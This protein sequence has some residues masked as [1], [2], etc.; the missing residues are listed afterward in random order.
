VVEA[1]SARRGRILPLDAFG[2]VSFTQAS[3]VKDGQSVSIRQ[4][5]GHPITMI[6]Q[7][8]QALAR[9]STLAEDG[10]SFNVLQSPR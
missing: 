4:A 10:A 5:G 2:L 6:G 9:P 8:G 7:R 3:T 1:P